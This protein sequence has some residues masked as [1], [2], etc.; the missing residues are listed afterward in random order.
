[1]VQAAQLS[2][3]GPLFDSALLVSLAER[4]WTDLT[5]GCRV[6][7]T[8]VTV[9]PRTVPTTERPLG[10]VE[11]AQVIS[12]GALFFVAQ[13]QLPPVPAAETLVVRFLPIGFPLFVFPLNTL[14]FRLCRLPV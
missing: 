7:T 9:M 1:M 8:D 14:G 6:L 2:R 4:V 3:R 11:A 12:F 10:E 13:H 5:E